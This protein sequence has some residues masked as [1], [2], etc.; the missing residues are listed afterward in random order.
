MSRPRRHRIIFFEPGITYFK[1]AG[2]PLRHLQEVVIVLE[3]LEALRLATI[4]ELDQ[5]DAAKK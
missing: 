2:V 3:E 1:P 4:E 5:K